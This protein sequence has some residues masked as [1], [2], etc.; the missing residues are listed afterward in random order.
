M[1]TALRWARAVGLVLLLCSATLPVA[2]VTFTTNTLISYTNTALDGLDIVV[3]NCTLTVDGQHTF[4]SLLIANGAKVT[5]SWQPSGFFWTNF[6][7]IDQAQVLTGTDP[8]V[9]TPVN[10]N[11]VLLSFTVTDTGKTVTYTNGVD[12]VTSSVPGV[13]LAISRTMNSAIPDGAT[14]LISYTAQV[15]VLPAGLNLS[16]LG[17]VTVSAGGAINANGLGYAAGPGA[18]IPGTAGS[19]GSYGG[20]GGVSSGGA[21]GLVGYGSYD[22]PTD[23]G[24]GG[25]DSYVG[26]GGAG[27]G[28]VRITASGTVLVNGSI[29]AN[30][31]PGT[32][33]RAGGGAGGS[34]WI[35]SPSFS[36]TGAVSAN[37]GAGELPQ[38]GGGGGGRISI[39]CNANSFAGTVTAYGGG[40]FNGGGAGS[41][42]TQLTGR[43][44]LVLVDNGGKTGTNSWLWVTNG[45]DVVVQGSAGVSPAAAWNAGNVTISSNSSLATTP[46]SQIQINATNLTLQHGAAIIADEA[47]YGG[48]QG[49][50]P[51]HY[52]NSPDLHYWGGGGGYGGNGGLGYTNSS[53][54]TSYG[55][56]TLSITYGSGGGGNNTVSF[57]GSGG[58]AMQLTI[59]RTSAGG[60]C[61][62]RERREWLDGWRRRVRWGYRGERGRVLRFRLDSCQWR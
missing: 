56:I 11:G 44:G 54:G 13:W 17:N 3:T 58:G 42:Y 61:H 18:G 46:L 19:G 24:S 20:I 47:G 41:I 57:G 59:F 29:Q 15:A 2:A 38:G 31:G 39:E 52:F 49:Q 10:T 60:R 37:G 12:Y 48:S 4:A 25:G 51:G 1:K 53:G 30:G 32:N 7:V 34:I 28:A 40:G 36:G 5:H 16:V 50:G 26:P 62:F 14:V 22:Q 55:S 23:L 6:S 35:I 27:G 21:A 9:L 33:N 8:I 43:N 45:A